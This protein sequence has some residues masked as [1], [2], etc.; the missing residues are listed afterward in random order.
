MLMFELVSAIVF[1]LISL[2]IC[3]MAVSLPTGLA[4]SFWVSSGAFPLIMGII[5]TLL[6]IWWICD[7]I[8]QIKE[9]KRQNPDKPKT[10]WLD[11]VIGD[12]T[13]KIHFVVIVIAVLVYVFLLIPLCGGL[14]REYGFVL[15][16]FIFL[17]V[18]IKIFNEISILK[19]IVIS[20]VSVTSIYVVF[21]YALRVLMPT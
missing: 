7:M 6:S 19:T 1:L 8:K 9:D 15:A 11:E 3:Y 13:K 12:K 20:A 18:T 2:G 21:H 17:G 4:A 16:S 14:S 5:L 10:P